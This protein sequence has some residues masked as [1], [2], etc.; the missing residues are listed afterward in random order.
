MTQLPVFETVFALV[1]VYAL[2][3]IVVSIL[4]EM[5]NYW[6]KSRSRMLVQAI[7]QLLS[8]PINKNYGELLLEHYLIKNLFNP[9]TRQPPQYISSNLFAEALIDV[10]AQQAR[11]T[12]VKLNLPKLDEKDGSI[13]PISDS[14]N[15]APDFE[16]KETLHR[17]RTGLES[18][19]PSPFRDAMFSIYDKSGQND[20]A[21]LKANLTQWYEDYMER[22]GEWYKVKQSR[23]ALFFGFV[24]AI[25]LNLDSI[26]LFR[27]LSMDA[28]LRGSLVQVAEK[29]ADNYRQLADS[30]RQNVQVL[31]KL[32]RENGPDSLS[33]HF[34]RRQIDL[35]D[36]VSN[37]YLERADSVLGILTGMGIPIGWSRTAAPLSWF[38]GQKMPLQRPGGAIGYFER[39][40][41]RFSILYFLGIAI[42][43]FALSTGA[44]FWFEVLLKL[45]N[46]RRSGKKPDEEVKKR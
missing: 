28:Q 26:H 40:H 22:V 4:I 14:R 18:M 21:N 29:F 11:H 1:L 6:R 23:N 45:A 32:V 35:Q 10:I 8:D 34:L 16:I 39:Y 36:S 20:Y 25:G 41:S 24:V 2:L 43:G 42:S 31:E 13:T 27:A 19:K 37:A 3:S 33:T 38:Q 5:W 15:T 46:I 30:S 44:P 7:H 12:L 9:D 17:F